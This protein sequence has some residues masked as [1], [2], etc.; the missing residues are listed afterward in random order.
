MVKTLGV[1]FSAIIFALPLVYLDS[2]VGNGSLI[3]FLKN[4]SIGIVATVL[5]LNIA[6]VTFLLG[7]LVTLET[8]ANKPLF[9]NT[10]KEVRHN[11]YFMTVMFFSLLFSVTSI[12]ANQLWSINSYNFNPLVLVS[13]VIFILIFICLFEIIEAI[14]QATKFLEENK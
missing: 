11:V 6:T 5:A 12:E 8:K 4:Q 10:K 2:R 3:S 7:H 14:F 13:T 1:I 9:K